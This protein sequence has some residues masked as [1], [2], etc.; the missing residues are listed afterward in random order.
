M[1]RPGR[2]TSAVDAAASVCLTPL[3]PL[4]PL[5]L[6]FLW[7][8]PPWTPLLLQNRCEGRRRWRC[9]RGGPGG[10]VWRDHS[11]GGVRAAGPPVHCQVTW[12]YGFMVLGFDLVFSP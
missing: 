12:F 4:F 3:F 1:S 9:R 10:R 8:L 2:N 6:L 11:H 7:T 5:F